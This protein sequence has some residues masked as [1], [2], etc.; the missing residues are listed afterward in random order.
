M[1]SLFWCRFGK[2]QFSL[3]ESYDLFGS[4]SYMLSVKIATSSIML[5]A[6]KLFPK[7]IFSS[8]DLEGCKLL[9]NRAGLGQSV[10]PTHYHRHSR[11]ASVNGE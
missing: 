5:A 10:A 2:Q 4:M 8:G 7:P 9:G 3:V 6:W 1:I 11:E